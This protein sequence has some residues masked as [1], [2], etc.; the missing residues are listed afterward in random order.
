MIL[1]ERELSA[2]F[3]EFCRRYEAPD[4]LELGSKQSIPGRSTMHKQ[5][6]P[7]AKTFIGTDF[8][9]GGDVDFLADIHDLSIYLNAQDTF[10]KKYDIIL[11]P[12]VFEHFYNPFMA[13]EEIAKALKPGGVVFVSTHNCYLLHGYPNDYWRFTTEGLKELAVQAGL[14]V[15]DAAYTFPCKIVSERQGEQAPAFLLVNLY[16]Q[17]K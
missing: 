2:P 11:A 13:M 14:E 7:N 3:I 5:W 16:A 6:F 9:E 10:P 15:I 1:E 8:D 4:V 12:S 17:K